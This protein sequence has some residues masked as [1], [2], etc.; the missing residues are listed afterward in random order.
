MSQK[1]LHFDNGR[2]LHIFSRRIY[3]DFNVVLLAFGP[4]HVASGLNVHSHDD[5]DGVQIVGRV[6][7]DEVGSTSQDDVW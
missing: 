1:Y 2:D 4:K 5:R 7:D 3:L 6:E